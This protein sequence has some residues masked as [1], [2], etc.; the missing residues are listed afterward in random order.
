MADELDDAPDSE[1]SDD[2]PSGDEEQDEGS[3]VDDDD[4]ALSA[5]DEDRVGV[6]PISGPRE[7]HDRLVEF[8]QRDVETPDD[9]IL[10][11]EVDGVWMRF[12]PIYWFTGTFD[13][14]WSASCGYDRQETY[15]EWVSKYDPD[16]KKYV[17]VP[18]TRTRIVT[19]WRPASGRVNGSFSELALAVAEG[20]RNLRLAC[21]N[22][23][24]DEV[25]TT[26]IGRLGIRGDMLVPFALSASSVY[27]DTIKDRV[28]N[29]MDNAV[30]RAIPGDRHR[31]VHWSGTTTKHAREVYY[32]FW[33]VTYTYRGQYFR[34]ILDAGRSTTMSG[35]APRDADR[36]EA[37]G[38]LSTA[39]ESLS[40]WRRRTTIWVI[41]LTAIYYLQGCGRSFLGYI[42]DVHT[43]EGFHSWFWAGSSHYLIGTGVGLGVAF[44]AFSL[45]ISVYRGRE[46][47]IRSAA[48]AGKRQVL[49]RFQQSV[50]TLVGFPSTNEGRMPQRE[51]APDAEQDAPAATR[52][53]RTLHMVW[54]LAIVLIS[55]LVALGSTV[56]AAPSATTSATVS[57]PASDSAGA[58]GG[59]TPTVVVAGQKSIVSLAVQGDTLF[60]AARDDDYSASSSPGAVSAVVPGTD[61]RINFNLVPPYTR[62]SAVV[63]DEQFVYWAAWNPDGDASGAAVFRAPRAGGTPKLLASRLRAIKALALD[64]THL[65]AASLV[66]VVRVKKEGSLPANVARFPDRGPPDYLPMDEVLDMHL[67][68]DRV[69]LI[70]WG[71]SGRGGKILACPKS[72]GSCQTLGRG[73]DLK[74]VTSDSSSVFWIQGDTPMRVPKTG[75]NPS[76]ISS[77]QHARESAIAGGFLYWSNREDNGKGS[78]VR[79]RVSDGVGRREVVVAGD[80]DPKLVLVT[81]TAVLWSIAGD[82]RGQSVLGQRLP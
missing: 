16:L 48:E 2:E 76:P 69:F 33:F 25:N 7:V 50:R 1:C 22:I 42:P 37:L 13:A 26:T 56:A 79:A 20:E 15:T 73:D 71:D 68:G 66:G 12:I 45:G 80:F 54:A 70:T 57:S 43:I 36:S 23:D 52:D 64:S 19:D 59:A 10:V 9:A 29:R 65:F 8:L 6:N 38:N 46:Q 31:D 78:I 35:G 39:Q 55:A 60:F 63:A 17:K 53:H 61:K 47:A 41:A 30:E 3:D 67:D 28:N 81:G 49:E 24:M 51:P 77:G 58:P 74:S 34:C 18:E 14:G 11:V 62:P 75:G 82:S 21:L 5:E 40:A 44:V 32:P 72:G 4:S 27:Q